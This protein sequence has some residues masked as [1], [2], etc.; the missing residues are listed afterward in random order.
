MERGRGTGEHPIN[1]KAVMTGRASVTTGPPFAGPDPTTVMLPGPVTAG[2]AGLGGAG[3]GGAAAAASRAD[4]PGAAAAAEASVLIGAAQAARERQAQAAVGWA[5]SLR[6]WARI[7]VW[8]V[9][10]AAVLFALSGPTGVQLVAGLGAL[11]IGQLGAIALA[12][13]FAGTAARRVGL[14]GLLATLLGTVLAAAGLGAAGVG[15]G[16]MPAG[17][18]ALAGVGV[19]AL[20]TGWFAFA[21]AVLRG[22]VLNDSD[23]VVLAVA[24]GAGGA[25]V[26]FGLTA[27][28][29]IA[30]LL[31]LA[32][33]LGI[34]SVAGRLNRDD[35]PG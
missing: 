2:D 27:L 6:R 33:G 16:A 13:L 14:A 20:M 19:A 23:A 11:A 34:A 22:G 3:L 18:V 25:S 29:L 10:G 31:L 21:V 12:A 26:L 32:A 15:A 28:R 35:E 5:R 7:A 30:A 1:G 24:I 8:A 9:P 4:D 17:S